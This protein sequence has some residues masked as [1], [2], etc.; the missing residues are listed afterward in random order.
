[1]EDAR[2]ADR[3]IEILQAAVSQLVQ[4]GIASFRVRDVSTALGTSSGLIHY[5]FDTKDRLIT[6]AFYYEAQRQLAE[7]ERIESSS[8]SPLERLLEALTLYGPTG[9]AMGWRLW[10]DAWSESL[11]NPSLRDA[12]DQVSAEWERRV[13]A[14]IVALADAEQRAINRPEDIAAR[15][16]AWIDGESV[17][18]VLRASERGLS[19]KPDESLRTLIR[20]YLR[21]FDDSR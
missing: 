1:M 14:L 2:A 7:L 16:L 9:S 6:A 12:M 19:S 21:G 4:R 15:L 18:I 8:A 13:S 10:I 11:R 17:R 3:S 20:S 5:H